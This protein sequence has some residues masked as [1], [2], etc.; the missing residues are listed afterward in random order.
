[1]V[2][3]GQDDHVRD[4][5]HM[6]ASAGV[7]AQQLVGVGG[8][9][10]S[11]FAEPCAGAPAGTPDALDRTATTELTVCVHRRDGGRTTW[12]YVG[13]GAVQALELSAES[14]A[15]LLPAVDRALDLVGR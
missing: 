1:V 3:H 10:V 14:W 13:D 8:G 15:R 4:R 12:V 7:P 6:S 2:L 9:A 11:P 5:S